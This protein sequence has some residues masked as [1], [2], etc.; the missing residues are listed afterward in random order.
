MRKTATVPGQVVSPQPCESP[1]KLYIQKMIIEKIEINLDY[2]PHSVGGRHPGANI[3]NIFQI[4]GFNLMLP[5]IEIK[6]S[7]DLQQAL[8]KAWKFW[9][10]HI[11]DKELVKLIS[12]LGPMTTLTNLG[13]ALYDVISLP[14]NSD[15]AIDGT[16]QALVGLIK[17][18]SIESIKL[19]ETCMSGAYTILQGFGNAAG[20]KMPSKQALVRP[21]QNIQTAVD[22]NQ[23]EAHH[24]KYRG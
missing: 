11:R 5:K 24:N 22:R 21:L 17:T 15:S 2:I 8:L 6:G 19:V 14:Y 23:I 18:F 13:T 16:K 3:L 10:K 20:I 4:E 12:G 1:K 9:F 7:R